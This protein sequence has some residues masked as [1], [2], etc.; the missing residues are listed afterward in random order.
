MITGVEAVALGVP[1]LGGDSSFSGRV[2]CE[3]RR[4]HVD[5]FESG[6]TR[7]DGRE[8]VA[9]NAYRFSRETRTL[10]IA[11]LRLGEPVHLVSLPDAAEEL[12]SASPHVCGPDLYSLR[13]TLAPRG[14]LLHW[15][16]ESPAGL[17]TLRATYSM[18]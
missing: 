6:V 1:A 8:F 16:I 14:L 3:P 13:I 12:V 11:H 4:L 5:W 10:H 17:A 18:P 7:R 15:H 9:T 2:R